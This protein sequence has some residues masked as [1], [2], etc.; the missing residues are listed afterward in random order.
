[1]NFREELAKLALP[2]LDDYNETDF[3]VFYKEA[4]Q[5]FLTYEYGFFPKEPTK[6]EFLPLEIDKR[7]CAGRAPLEK[8]ELRADFDGKEFCFPFFVSIPKADKKLPF[9]ISMNF[10]GNIPNC[11]LPSE[12][13]CDNGYAVL[14]FCYNDVTSDDNDFSNGLAGVL[15]DGKERSDTDCGKI[16]MWSWAASRVMDYALTRSELD[17]KKGI[18][19][20]H[21]RLGKTALLTGAIDNRFFC[22]VSNDSGCSGASIHRGKVGE[23]IHDICTNFPYWFC[24]NYHKYMGKDNTLPFDQHMLVAMN[25]SHYVYVASAIEDEWA[26]PKAELLSCYCAGRLADKLGIANAFPYENAPKLGENFHDGKIGYHVR[27][28]CHFLSRDDWQRV[29]SFLNSK[30]K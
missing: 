17:P 10:N 30:L 24:K 3:E 14:S 28:G 6:I 15:Y 18:V 1:M 20:G 27:S 8:I 22:A 25:L 5:L 21:S 19:I 2:Y 4:K 13:I 23:K 26:D 16:L 29:I 11:Y 7:F 12:E 9:F